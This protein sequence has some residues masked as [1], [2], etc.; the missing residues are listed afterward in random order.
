MHKEFKEYCKCIKDI[1]LLSFKHLHLQAGI[2]LDLIFYHFY[3]NNRYCL[4]YSERD[5]IIAL[6]T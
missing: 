5:M 1:I 4:F 3:I 6:I 2:G